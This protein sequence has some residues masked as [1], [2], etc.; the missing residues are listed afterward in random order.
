M[1]ATASSNS[2]GSPQYLSIPT[3][4]IMMIYAS[5]I[6]Y[7]TRSLLVFFGCCVFHLTLLVC[8]SVC[9][10]PRVLHFSKNKHRTRARAH[11]QHPTRPF[12]LIRSMYVPVYRCTGVLSTVLSSNH[13][14]VGASAL[15]V[16]APPATSKQHTGN[17]LRDITNKQTRTQTTSSCLH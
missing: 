9:G 6:I 12:D 7:H 2:I 1:R 15:F 4:C 14:A 3:C 10:T 17:N 8:L 5:H 13:Q 11:T 16:L